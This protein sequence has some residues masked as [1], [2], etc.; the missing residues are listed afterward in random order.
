MP[1]TFLGTDGF[2]LGKGFSAHQVEVAEVVRAMASQASES[3]LCADSSKYGNTGFSHILP[4]AEV[5]QI[6]TDDGLS[7]G[8]VKALEKNRISVFT[9]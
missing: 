6:I 3:I 4:L 2:S 9:V 1:D 5:D 7:R 8:N